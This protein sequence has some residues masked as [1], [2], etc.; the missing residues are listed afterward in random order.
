M[1]VS[2]RSSCLFSPG[3]GIEAAS[4]GR[5]WRRGAG[6]L[7]TQEGVGLVR[8]L[9]CGEGGVQSFSEFIGRVFHAETLFRRMLN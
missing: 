5:D 9:H 4:G 2:A 7:V 6:L 3:C 8:V 1:R